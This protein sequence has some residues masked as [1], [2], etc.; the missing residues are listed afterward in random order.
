MSIRIAYINCTVI[1]A[2]RFK[3][4]IDSANNGHYVLI[5]SV[6]YL[7]R[8]GLAA[9]RKRL[10][11]WDLSKKFIFFVTKIKFMVK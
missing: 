6:L 8:R 1:F 11:F 10:Y 9:K 2:H 3:S 4:M 5:L 7:V